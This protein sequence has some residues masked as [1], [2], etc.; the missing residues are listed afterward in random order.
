LDGFLSLHE[1]SHDLKAGNCTIM[2]L[3]LDFKKAYDSVSWPF[4]DD[5]LLA[6]GFDGAYVHRIMQLVY[7]GRTAIS[8]NGSVSLFSRM[9]G[10]WARATPF[11]PLFL[12]L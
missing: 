8:V 1:I 7:G 2:V 12:T 4:L 3:K 10:A 9:V 11:H 5:V 6:K